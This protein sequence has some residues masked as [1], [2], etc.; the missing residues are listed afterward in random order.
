MGISIFFFSK[1]YF[2]DFFKNPFY[3]SKGI[4]GGPRGVHCVRKNRK[5]SIFQKSSEMVLKGFLDVF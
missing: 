1:K 3:F 4:S 5:I 2:A